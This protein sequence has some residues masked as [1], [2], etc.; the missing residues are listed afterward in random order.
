MAGVDRPTDRSIDRLLL[1]LLVLLVLGS[2]H[3]RDI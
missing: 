2:G 3:C 1:V